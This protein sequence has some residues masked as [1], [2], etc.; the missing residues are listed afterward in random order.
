MRPDTLIGSISMLSPEYYHVLDNAI[1]NETDPELFFPSHPANQSNIKMALAI[2]KR[3]P[4]QHECLTY[5][6]ENRISDGIWG[7][8]TPPMRQSIRRL[9]RNSA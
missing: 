1:C 2:C 5:A 6:L 3:C 4:V 8:A 7:G 9:E